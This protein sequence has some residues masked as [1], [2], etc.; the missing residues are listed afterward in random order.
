[1]KTKN[2]IDTHYNRLKFEYD[3]DVVLIN[4]DEDLIEMLLEKLK[5]I[6]ELEVEIVRLKENLNDL[7]I[8]YSDLEEEFDTFKEEHM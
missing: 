4:N 2:F 5:L 8:S 1:M 7:K 3:L 6:D